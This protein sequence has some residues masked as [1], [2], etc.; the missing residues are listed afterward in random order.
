MSDKMWREKE[1]KK[2]IENFVK[3]RKQYV[4]PKFIGLTQWVRTSTSQ[5]TGE[6]Y[7]NM[8]TCLAGQRDEL[9]KQSTMDKLLTLTVKSSLVAEFRS[10]EMAPA[11][12]TEIERGL[13][14]EFI[15][16]TARETPLES[17]TKTAE[18]WPKSCPRRNLTR[19]PT[20]SIEKFDN[21]WH[22][23][24]GAGRNRLSLPQK[25]QTENLPNVQKRRANPIKLHGEKIVREREAENPTP[26]ISLRRKVREIIFLCGA[27]TPVSSEIYT[28][29]SPTSP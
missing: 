8:H 25:R 1:E 7:R 10:I 29:P 11:T 3:Y 28:P 12:E 19:I 18:N 15:A 14:G 9:G 2:N 24:Y 27:L 16:K 21:V 13:A 4:T 22:L 26:P 20:H 23:E 17:P 6:T 5:T